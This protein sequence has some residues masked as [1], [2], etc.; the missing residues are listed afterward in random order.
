ML[1][2]DTARLKTP[3][4]GS[5]KSATIAAFRFNAHAS[6]YSPNKSGTATTP[7]SGCENAGLIRFAVASDPL[8]RLE[9]ALWQERA[10]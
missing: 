8:R 6:G 4:G 9:T 5:G 3:T 10:V 7:E 1:H 2:P